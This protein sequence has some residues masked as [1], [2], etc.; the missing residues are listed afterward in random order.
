MQSW[1]HPLK[2]SAVRRTKCGT[3]GHMFL[4]N[5]VQRVAV[6]ARTNI[7]PTS[8]Y[9]SQRQTFTNILLAFLERIPGKGHLNTPYTLDR[10]AAVSINAYPDIM[11]FDKPN[12]LWTD[13]RNSPF[14]PVFNTLPS[15]PFQQMLVRVFQLLA[16]SLRWCEKQLLWSSASY[17]SI[18]RSHYHIFQYPKLAALA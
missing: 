17:V 6:K 13:C 9:L 12:L 5:Q 3:E 14:Q 7:I 18:L 8:T 1:L 4:P 2:L 16:T 15:S 10:V 11:F